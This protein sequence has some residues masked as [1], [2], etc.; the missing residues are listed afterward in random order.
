MTPGGVTAL[1]QHRTPEELGQAS[2]RAYKSWKQTETDT[3]DLVVDDSGVIENAVATENDLTTTQLDEAREGANEGIAAHL[4]A[5][6]EFRFQ[7]MVAALLQALGYHVA[8][9]S[10]PGPDHGVDIVAY[11]DAIGAQK[12]RIKVQVK[13]TS[14]ETDASSIFWRTRASRNRN[15][16]VP[17][18][19]FERCPC[20]G[21]DAPYLPGHFD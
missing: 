9:I 13:H 11:P 17:C 20:R 19:V 5:M 7:E 3:T 2:V 8:W 16:Y 6:N 10:T 12:P 1:D 21:S 4:P 14:H 15:L 18:R